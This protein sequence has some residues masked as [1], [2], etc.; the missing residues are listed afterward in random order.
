M[1]GAYSVAAGRLFLLDC[2]GTIKVDGSRPPS[3]G[4]LA[5]L[6]AICADPKNF[7]IVMSG[8]P[9]ESIEAWFGSVE[10]LGL[11]AENGFYY[12]VPRSEEWACMDPTVDLSWTPV[13]EGI[14]KEYCER[15]DGAQLS[16]TESH[17]RWVFRDTDQEFGQ[18]QAHQLKEDIEQVI[19][20][21]V[22]E[23]NM[24][25]KAVVVHPKNVHRGTLVSILA[26]MMPNI[27]FPLEFIACFGDDRADE[28]TFAAI[29]T[30]IPENANI[31]LFTCTVGRKNSFA[32][33][34]VDGMENVELILTKCSEVSSSM[35][36]TDM[37]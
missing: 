10:N 11:A 37:S 24:S 35:P 19:A 33:F 14:M 8:R 29:N 22:I 17:M 23:V 34:F 26:T 20:P 2:E 3:D 32:D 18:W 21:G 13:V 4:M 12:K 31:S 28:D 9:R 27:D 5:A 1:L 36:A 7:V 30:H 16:L 15:T 6:R 25:T